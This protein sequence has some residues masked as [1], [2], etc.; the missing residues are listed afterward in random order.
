MLSLWAATVKDQWQAGEFERESE[1]ETIK[2]TRSA[3][4]EASVIKRIL[5]MDYE[6]LKGALTDE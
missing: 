1:A 4:A 3:L 5:D 6:Q 2:A